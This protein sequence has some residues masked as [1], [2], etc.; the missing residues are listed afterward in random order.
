[1]IIAI[2]V[3]N[4]S[5]MQLIHPVTHVSRITPQKRD[6][7]RFKQEEYDSFSSIYTAKREEKERDRAGEAFDA[8]T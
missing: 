4:I 6:A 8:Q 2:Y 7:R 5:L 3:E 1:M